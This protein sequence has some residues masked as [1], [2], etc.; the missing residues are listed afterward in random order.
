MG[1]PLIPTSMTLNDL[2]RRNSP[3]RYL[4][5]W[6][7]SCCII[8]TTKAAIARCNMTLSI[9]SIIRLLVS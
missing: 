9:K 5:S 1:F 7:V 2:E 4:I 6:I 3:Y 8:V